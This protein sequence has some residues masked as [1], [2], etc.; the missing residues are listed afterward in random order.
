M[1]QSHST[2]GKTAPL[3]SWDVYALQQYS[4]T[5]ALKEDVRQ[6]EMLARLGGWVHSW[7][8]TQKVVQERKTI[9]VTS[10]NQQILFASSSLFAMTGY[11]PQE[12]LG[13]SPK[14]FQG[15]ETSPESKALIRSAL[16]AQQPFAALLTNYQ[17]GGSAYT[18]QVEGFPVVDHRGALVNYI[19]FEQAVF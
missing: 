3:L 16:Q 8:F 6:L 9:L 10:L 1:K 5:H 12:V 11:L 13:K 2:I 4:A 7:N 14:I 19:A 18:C 15:P 17:K